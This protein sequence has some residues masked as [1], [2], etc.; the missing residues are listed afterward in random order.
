M[1]VVGSFTITEEN[2]WGDELISS[3]SVRFADYDIT[4]LIYRQIDPVVER[5]ILTPSI[6]IKKRFDELGFHE[7]DRKTVLVD[8]APYRNDLGD[9]ADIT[10]D[11]VNLE[12]ILKINGCRYLRYLLSSS[13]ERTFVFVF[14]NEKHFKLLTLTEIET[15]KCH[16]MTG[17]YRCLRKADF[18]CGT[19][20][21][22]I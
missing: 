13:N 14:V 20:T 22:M 11:N 21:K 18:F 16:V 10:R 12:N 8:S 6:S 3:R 7:S 17:T 15:E 4:E 2:F 9:T 19:H 1:R 5:S